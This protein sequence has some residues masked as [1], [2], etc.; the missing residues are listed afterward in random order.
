MDS[1]E[2]SSGEH[3]CPSNTQGLQLPRFPQSGAC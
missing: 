2:V 1:F 3:L